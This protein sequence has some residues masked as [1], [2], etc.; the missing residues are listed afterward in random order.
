LVCLPPLGQFRIE[1]SPPDAVIGRSANLNDGEQRGR[2]Q[3]D[4]Q[5]DRP[6][7]QL[8]IDRAIILLDDGCDEFEEVRDVLNGEKGID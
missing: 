5:H 4:A 2:R 8:E 1:R 6:R 7:E 3:G